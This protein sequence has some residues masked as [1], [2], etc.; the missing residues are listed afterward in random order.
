MKTFKEIICNALNDILATESIT[1]KTR[2]KGEEIKTHLVSGK[3]IPGNFV[4]LE[5]GIKFNISFLEGGDKRLF[6][7]QRDNRK[8][9]K[10]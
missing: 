7:D 8:K 4:V 10:P 2:L 6:L 9:Y 3:E 1:E 5:N